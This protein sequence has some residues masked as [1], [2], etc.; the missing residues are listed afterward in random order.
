MQEKDQNKHSWWF[1]KKKLKYRTFAILVKEKGGKQHRCG[2]HNEAGTKS[3]LT[4]GG[5][6]DTDIICRWLAIGWAYLGRR[7]TGVRVNPLTVAD[8]WVTDT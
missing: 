6:P 5:L 3:Q 2:A 1:N 7:V 4:C 8:N